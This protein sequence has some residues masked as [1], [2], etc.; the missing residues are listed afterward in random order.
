MRLFLVV[1]SMACAGLAA[2]SVST[3]ESVSA[4][5]LG[6]RAQQLLQEQNPTLEIPPIT[7]PEDLEAVVGAATTCTV[8][9]PSTGTVFPVTVTVTS[10]EGTDVGIDVRLNEP[11][12]SSS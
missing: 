9:D 5:N 10:A 11:S 8:T 4:E 12:A 2:C 1:I 7:C 6:T 3:T